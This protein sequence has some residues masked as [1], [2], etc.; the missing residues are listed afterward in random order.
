MAALLELT[1]SKSHALTLIWRFAPSSPYKGEEL[2][3][4]GF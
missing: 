1:P 4:V 3:R 2:G